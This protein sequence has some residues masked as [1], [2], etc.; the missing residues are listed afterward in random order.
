MEI[1]LVYVHPLNEKMHV[2]QLHDYS[3]LLFLFLGFTGNFVIW[4]QLWGINL[5]NFYKVYVFNFLQTREEG[6]YTFVFWKSKNMHKNSK[7]FMSE[8]KWQLGFALKYSRKKV[9]KIGEIKLV[10]CITVKGGDT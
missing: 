5:L 8:M 1:Q 7:V 10:K 9:E 2:S 6:N 3:L 4:G